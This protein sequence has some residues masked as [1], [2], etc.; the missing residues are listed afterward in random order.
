VP[1][2]SPKAREDRATSS[3]A[4]IAAFNGNRHV[5]P[6]VN[7]PIKAYAPGSP[8]KAEIKSRLKQMA[9]ERVEMP[10]V[11]G[12]REV[13]TG[14]TAP[15]VMPHDHSHVLGQ[16]H[17]ARRQDVEA[18]IAAAGEAHR[19]WSAWSWEDRAA[20]FLKAAELLATTWRSTL[21]AATMLGQSK[22]VFQAEIDA[23]CELI[24]F[25]RF[26]P[27]YA[28]QLYGEQPLSDHAMWNQ[29]EY[30]PLEGFVYAVTP[31]NFTSIG[32]N[33]PTAP[34]LMGS[35]VLWKPASSAM[36]SAW[37]I[38]RLLEEAG[39][40]P[41]VINFVPGDAAMISEVAL[42]HRDLA[43]VHFTGST[44][45]FN[46]MWKTIGAGMSRYRSYPRIVG[47]TGGKDFIVAHAS[48]DAQALAVAIVRGG[49]EYQGQK[50]SAVSR[51]YVPR[52]IWPDVRDRAVAMMREIKMGDVT[53]FRNF[54]G[55][56]IDARAFE[57]IG[58]YLAE[59]KRS[60]RIVSGGSARGEKG[61]FIEPTLVEADDPAHRLLCEE[62]FGP[63]VTAHVYDDARWAETLQVVDSTSPYALTGS[64]FAQDRRAVREASSALRNAAGNFY[65]NDK[66]TG[67]VVGQQP[68]GGAR[69]SGTNDKAGSKLNL[70]RWVSARTVKETFS[71]PRDYRYPF[72][73]EE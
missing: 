46:S 14:D 2:T 12:G 57:K 73:S 70:V 44:S 60:A 28:E 63:V 64:V 35:T 51:V 24:D 62:I 18:A 43:G 47:E 58:E 1:E 52:S 34:A 9:G 31:F 7:E 66:P 32:G 20:V 55:A 42:S 33:L 45:V 49:F 25:W 8:E 41:G 11:I 39:L 40:P 71:P 4:P 23:A 50:C 65:V 72:M 21:N 27:F 38:L 15:T 10:L 69:S 36:L 37:Y 53:D 56:V 29:L 22:T 16:W 6:P 61:W 54:M 67:A 26:N 3:A 19:E 5:P 68:F 30:R 48:A 13:R 17:R 59:A